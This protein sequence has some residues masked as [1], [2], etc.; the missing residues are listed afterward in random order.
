MNRARR[1]RG[2]LLDRLRPR[3]DAGMTLAEVVVAMSL[4]SVFMVMFTSAAIGVFRAVNGHDAT[5][6]AQAQINTVFMRLDREIRYASAISK[7]GVVGTDPYIEYLTT[8]TGADVCTELRLHLSVDTVQLQRRTWTKVTT[9]SPTPTPWAPLASGFSG[10]QPFTFVADPEFESQQLR[11]DLTA[12]A[13]GTGADARS[14]RT[15]VTFT[16]LNAPV[17]VV[18]ATVCSEGRTLP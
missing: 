3:D 9:G 16:A 15:Y 17:S 18:T 5:A 4:M 13:G 12:K 10:T 1:T 11:L 14:K 8:N 7:E 2:G 6:T